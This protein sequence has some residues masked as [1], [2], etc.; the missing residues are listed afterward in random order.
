MKKSR[1]TDSQI[2][3]VLK[4]A[5]CGTPVPELCR[6]SHGSSSYWQGVRSSIPNCATRQSQYVRRPLA[7]KRRQPLITVRG[8]HCRRTRAVGSCAAVRLQSRL[9]GLVGGR[10]GGRVGQGGAAFH[11][12]GVSE[13][14]FSAAARLHALGGR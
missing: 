10:C 11:E 7:S 6:S 1:F 4:Q 9:P 14:L 5:E 3:A 13:D 2:I 8:G 12:T